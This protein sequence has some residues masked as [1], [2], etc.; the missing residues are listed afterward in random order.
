[1]PEIRVKDLPLP[2][3]FKGLHYSRKILLGI[4]NQWLTPAPFFFSAEWRKFL[5]AKFYYLVAKNLPKVASW[6]PY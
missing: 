1:M 2:V 3:K 4:R 6:H 5:G